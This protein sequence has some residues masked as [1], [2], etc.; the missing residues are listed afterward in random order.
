MKRLKEILRAGGKVIAFGVGLYGV[1]MTVFLLLRPLLGEQFILIAFFNQYLPALFFPSFIFL[2]STLVLR[3]MRLMVLQLPAL[4]GFM[5]LYRD[6]MLP[7]PADIQPGE[8]RFTLLTYNIM[9]QNLDY[10][11]VEAVMRAADSD[12][13]VVQ[14]IIPEAA[15]Y[16][17]PALLD[18]YPYTALHTDIEQ[19]VFSR[20]PLSEDSSWRNL[21][22]LYQRVQVELE[23][24]Q[25]IVYNV[26]P[27]PSFWWSR[28]ILDPTRHQAEII[29]LLGRAADES[30]PLLLAGDFNM[31]D[32]SD[33]YFR[34]R[35]NYGDAFRAEGGGLGLTISSTFLTTRVDYVFYNPEIVPVEAH[36]GTDTGGSDHYPV[37]VELSLIGN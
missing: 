13:I 34:V 12:V 25:V 30:G 17:Q 29:D 32:Q 8:T 27:L 23:D 24:A 31:S 36:V 35:A 21:H 26:H 2:L 5:L 33:D 4:L 28:G 10:A 11:H 16:L 7:P 14:E 18:V 37:W 6:V 3:R 20:Y 1:L 9:A 19:G 22:G 15:E